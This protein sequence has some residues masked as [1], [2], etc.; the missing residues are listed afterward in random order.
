MAVERTRQRVDPAA[1]RSVPC[2]RHRCPVSVR[3]G[4]ARQR[5]G[6]AAARW[7][8]SADCPRTVPWQVDED[9]A[10]GCQVG[11]SRLPAAA[12]WRCGSTRAPGPRP[13]SRDSVRLSA[14]DMVPASPSF[15]RSS[16]NRPMPWAHCARGS[17]R[18]LHV[19]MVTR[20]CFTDSRPNSER[21]QA[22]SSRPE[23]PRDAEYLASMQ[24]ERYPA[25]AESLHLKNRF[26]TTPGRSRVKVLDV[27]AD[28]R[29]DDL[30]R[31]SGRRMH[32]S[33]A[34]VAEY[35]RFDPRP[36]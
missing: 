34:S 16:L 2:S 18:P 1:R 15:L 7:R 30:R 28:H 10:P 27:T 35:R 25:A 33:D 20:P 22:C 32:G 11:R 8:P 3:P 36:L 26:A 13:S 19:P 24:R 29:A 5:H 31:W 6:G 4:R 21:K 23:K 9:R 17:G 14:I 12:F